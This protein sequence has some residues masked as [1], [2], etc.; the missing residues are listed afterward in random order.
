[1]TNTTACLH[2]SY[3]KSL[4]VTT[5]WYMVPCKVP[6]LSNSEALGLLNRHSMPPVVCAGNPLV[7]NAT[8]GLHLWD[9]VALDTMIFQ[10]WPWRC[11]LSVTYYICLHKDIIVIAAEKDDVIMHYWPIT[12]K[13]KVDIY[14]GD[15]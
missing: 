4:L 9:L 7:S 1:V 3:E 13:V 2:H 5:S 8:L 6:V 14:H 11:A 15:W 12:P 10:Y